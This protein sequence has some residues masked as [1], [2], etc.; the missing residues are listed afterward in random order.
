[1]D[2]PLMAVISPLLSGYNGAL[3]FALSGVFPDKSMLLGFD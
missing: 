2:L 1:M 3:L